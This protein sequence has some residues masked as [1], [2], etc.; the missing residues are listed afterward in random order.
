MDCLYLQLDNQDG[1]H[2]FRLDRQQ[3][4]ELK[5]LID[6]A[7]PRHEKEVIVVQKAIYLA[8]LSETPE[9]DVFFEGWENHILGDGK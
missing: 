5:K 8:N 1:D 4:E 3:A 9:E 2:V 6:I 7:L